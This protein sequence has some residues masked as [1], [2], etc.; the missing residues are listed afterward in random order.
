MES[1]KFYRGQY[2]IKML[3][4]KDKILQRAILHKNVAWKRIKFYRGQYYIKMLQGKDRIL[5]WAVL[6]KKMSW[7]R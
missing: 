7:K 3:H 2:Y 4:G 1:T 6:H 5:Q